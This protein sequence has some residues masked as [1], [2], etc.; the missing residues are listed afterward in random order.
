MFLSGPGDVGNPMSDTLKFLRL[1]GAIEPDDVIMLIAALTG[2]ATFRKPFLKVIGQPSRINIRVNLSIKKV[3][4]VTL[5][6][7]GTPVA[8]STSHGVTASSNH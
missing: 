3:T 1:L 7:K 2:V 8:V 5:K 6:I 4:M